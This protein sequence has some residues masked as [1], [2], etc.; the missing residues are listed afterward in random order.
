MIGEAISEM[1]TRRLE[2]IKVKAKNMKPTRISD[3]EILSEIKN[4]TIR[5]LSESVLNILERIQNQSVDKTQA[6]L[7]LQAHKQLIQLVVFD[8]NQ[9][10][11][12]RI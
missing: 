2:L 1:D 9:R 3:G 8:Y 4:P 11:A 7:E 10:Q 5:K 12:L 6:L